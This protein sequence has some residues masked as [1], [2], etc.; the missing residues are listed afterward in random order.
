MVAICVPSRGLIY[1]HTVQSV[2]EGMQALNAVGVATTYIT[3]HDLPIPQS[4]DTCVQKALANSAVQTI[5]FIEE[6]MYLEPAAIVALATSSEPFVTLQYNDKNGS[7][8]GIIHYNEDGEILWSGVGATAIKR[9]VFEAL[10]QPYFRADVRYKVVKKTLSDGRKVVTDF[11]ELEQRSDYQYGG[12][13][14][15]LCTRIRKLGFTL[16]KLE[17]YKAHHFQLVQL[18]EP[19]TNN[20]C[21]VIRQV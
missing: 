6:D 8:H 17:Q 16:K 20:G 18:G 1:S 15:D 4:H 19:H 7:P 5:L 9:H 2:I 21:H 3:T 12:L 13:D 14:V 11:E 10:G